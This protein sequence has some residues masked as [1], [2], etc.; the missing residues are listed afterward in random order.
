MRGHEN[1]LDDIFRVLAMPQH[2]PDRRPHLRQVELDQPVEGPPVAPHRL[3]HEFRF[4]VHRAQD[5]TNRLEDHTLPP[6]DETAS[7]C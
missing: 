5:A 7:T 6:E 3:P 4:L 1:F 2:P